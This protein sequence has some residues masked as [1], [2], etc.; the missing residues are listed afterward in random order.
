MMHKLATIDSGVGDGIAYRGKRFA[1]KYALPAILTI[2]G[3]MMVAGPVN[4]PSVAIGLILFL[5]A[6]FGFTAAEVR[7]PGDFLEYRR[8]WKWRRIE[9]GKVTQC[10]ASLVPAM[11]RLK[12]HRFIPPWGAIYFVLPDVGLTLA[13]PGGHTRFTS[14]VSEK[15]G[16]DADRAVRGHE[17]G[18]GMKAGARDYIF[19]GLIGCVWTLVLYSIVPNFPLGMISDNRSPLANVVRTEHAALTWPWGLIA[20]GVLLLGLFSVRNKRIV[21]VFAFCF[22]AVAISVL[23]SGLR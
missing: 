17:Y 5:C 20:C 2:A 4:L 9:A 16:S 3:A 22:G 12:L 21:W 19:S 1:I 7:L 8:F 10:R 18:P 13:C 6:A 23:I 15:F 11:G 14:R